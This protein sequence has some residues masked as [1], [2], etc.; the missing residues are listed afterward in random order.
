MKETQKKTDLEVQVQ[1]QPEN[2]SLE[3]LSNELHE[4]VLRI[5]KH[6]N[7]GSNAKNIPGLIEKIIQLRQFI[8]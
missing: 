3:Y 7:H 5:I 8:R 6:D 1:N 2:H 4:Y